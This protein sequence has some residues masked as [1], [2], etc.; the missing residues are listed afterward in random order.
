MEFVENERLRISKIYVYIY[1]LAE[2]WYIGKGHE[3]VKKQKISNHTHSSLTLS[4]SK[5]NY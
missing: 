1:N 5:I 4:H 3:K 2:D